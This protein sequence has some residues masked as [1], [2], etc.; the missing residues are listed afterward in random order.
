MRLGILLGLLAF[1]CSNGEPSNLQNGSDA[2]AVEASAMYDDLRRM[3]LD[4]KAGD[5][6]LDESQ[7][8]PFGVLMEIDI[9][10]ETATITSF[11]TG[12][13]S[14]YLSSGGGTIGGGEHESVATAARRFVDVAAAN[15]S[16]MTPATTH[17]RPGP[18]QVT[19]YVLTPQGIV[20]ASRAEQDLG[21]VK[22]DLSDLFYAGQDVLTAIRQLGG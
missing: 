10:G 2:T 18:G 13:A 9:D 15:V 1:G 8:A 20:S 21:E 6:G 4:M 22:S 5:L 12:D 3:A 11:A 14:L 17:P 19:F 16:A 7:Q